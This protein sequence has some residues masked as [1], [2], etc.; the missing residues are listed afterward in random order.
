M[1]VENKNRAQYKLHKA[2]T[3]L[4]YVAAMPTGRRGGVLVGFLNI[5]QT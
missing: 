1:F 3:W 5:L 4:Q 2:V